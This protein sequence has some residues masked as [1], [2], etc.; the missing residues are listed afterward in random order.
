MSIRIL[1]AD[2]H[3]ITRQGL[4]SLLDSQPD[5]Q[6]VA[7]A[8]E[9]RTAVSL[10]REMVPDVVIM[11]VTMPDL[12]GMEATRQIV[13]E[14]PNIK[15]IALSMHSDMLFVSEMQE[16]TVKREIIHN[17]LKKYFFRFI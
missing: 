16:A 13:S 15:I 17:R 11:D 10:V 1:L 12:N 5:M 2:D 7:E 14:F 8:E 4:R 3:K 9:G 6:V